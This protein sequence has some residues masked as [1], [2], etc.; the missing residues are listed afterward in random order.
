MISWLRTKAVQMF[1]ARL[2]TPRDVARWAFAK[3]ANRVAVVD[4]RG[5]VTYTELG[6]RTYRTAA[7]WRR[8]GVNCG[9]VVAVRLPDGIC[10]VEARLAAA[11]CGAV[12]N[13]L[14]PWSTVDQLVAAL[15]VV[16]P[17]VFIH[18][19]HNA[20]VCQELARRFPTMLQVS[21]ENG[22]P[23]WTSLD[24]AL[25][26][27]GSIDPEAT[28]SLGFT[29]GTTGTPKIT[30]A[31][32]GVYL[33]SIRLMVANVGVVPPGDKPDTTLVGIPLTGAGSGLLLPTVLAGGRLVIPRRYDAQSLI[34][35]IE[36]QRVTRLFTTPSL[37][38]DMLDHELLD[39]VDLSSLRNLIYGTEMMPVAKLEEALLRFGPILQQGY[40]SAEVLPPVSMLQPR[41]HMHNGR[42]AVREVLMSC[43]RV[44]PQVTVRIVDEDGSDVP[45]GTPGNV[46]VKS[47][48][49]FRGYG[50]GPDQGGDHLS[51]GFLRIGDMGMLD[52]KG[53]LTL[54]GRKPDVL[55]RDGRAIY[56]RYVEEALHDHPAIKE[57]AY[58][59][60]PQGL[61]MVFSLRRAWRDD[62]A[63]KRWRTELK[64][65]L[66]SRVLEWQLPDSYLLMDELP[67]S[68]LGKLLRR[69][70]RDH[71]MVVANNARRG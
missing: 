56:P 3:Y 42:P 50:Q 26:C 24:L 48:T 30:T 27:A 62:T 17:R 34:E 67:R 59:Q 16:E 35:C 65:H 23:E 43:G 25:P 71:L 70:V 37:L 11:E 1:L 39:K 44:V 69:E 14:A 61:V 60:G 47:P 64:L 32:H 53:Y 10:Q 28:L 33:T 15:S 21:L 63:L 57:A 13:L 4:A 66:R 52:S 18:D 49:L 2:K 51:G 31:T 6:Q 45:A 12:L 29:S 55:R 54:L 58:V 41:D 68:Q 19:G 46:L 36:Q 7:A 22:N 8:M 5:R 38:I 9:D 40:G 20:A